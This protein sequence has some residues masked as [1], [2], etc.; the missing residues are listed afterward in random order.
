M[1]IGSLARAAPSFP[2]TRFRAWC[3]RGATSASILWQAGPV[4]GFDR[5]EASQKQVGAVSGPFK[6][7]SG[8]S[9]SSRCSTVAI[10]H[11]SYQN[12]TSTCKLPAWFDPT[13]MAY[14]CSGL[15][16]FVTN[17]SSWANQ[18]SYGS[19]WAS[20]IW[21]SWV[22]LCTRP[23]S[24]GPKHFKSWI[25]LLVVRWSLSSICVRWMMGS[26]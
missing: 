20:K 23:A 18:S 3:R 19:K 11:D 12:S 14:S 5:I 13:L 10:C 17:F 15:E 2:W 7:T 1:W 22:A 8:R 21:R 24:M 16:P 4:D 9:S 6:G 26:W 25:G